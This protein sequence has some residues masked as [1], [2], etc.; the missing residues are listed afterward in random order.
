MVLEGIYG[1]GLLF[2]GTGFREPMTPF[3]IF[4]NTFLEV[5]IVRVLEGV[6][7]EEVQTNIHRIGNA[8][9]DLFR[10]RSN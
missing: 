6:E 5:N 2:D 7:V 10:N 8:D 9:E 1:E 3:A 4:S